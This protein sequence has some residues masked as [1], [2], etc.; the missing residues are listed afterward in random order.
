MYFATKTVK[1]R[2]YRYLQHSWR[3]GKRVKT[4]SW[5]LGF[6]GF[7][8]GALIGGPFLGLALGAPFALSTLGVD[9][10]E[11]LRGTKWDDVTTNKVTTNK[12]AMD[13]G[14]TDKGKTDDEAPKEE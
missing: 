8:G 11:T 6:V 5:C 4:K 12:V 14:K 13:K 7:V 3:E 10:K 1:N 2:C 9:W